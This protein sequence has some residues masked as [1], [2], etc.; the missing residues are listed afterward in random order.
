[1]VEGKKRFLRIRISMVSVAL[2]SM[3][4]MI[5]AG[6]FSDP[7]TNYFV[8]ISIGVLVLA[9][10]LTIIYLQMRI[11]WIAKQRADREQLP[12]SP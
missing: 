10:I 9:L 12:P 11:N 5:L 3:G 6:S 4:L 2:T 7:W 1:V 8:N